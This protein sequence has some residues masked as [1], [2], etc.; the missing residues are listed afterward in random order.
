MQHPRQPIP[1]S[2]GAS[3]VLQ[4][5]QAAT[6]AKDGHASDG[7][8]A[9]RPARRAHHAFL[10]ADEDEML[11]AVATYFESGLEA[12]E[13]AV[14]I[15]TAEHAE[16][17]RQAMGRSYA[18][19]EVM[20]A[21]ATLGLFMLDGMPDEPLFQATVG[22]LLRERRRTSPGIR[23]FGEMVNVLMVRGHADAAI[24]LEAMWNRLAAQVDFELLC[25]Y[26]AACFEHPEGPKRRHQV[27]ATHTSFHSLAQTAQTA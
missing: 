8:V 16:E 21:Q 13:H 20:D 18:R 14:A 17:L 12:G 1:T 19:L 4:A 10:Y 9:Q 6:L 26:E 5:P 7:T 2:A 15:L 24:A 23:A 27:T 25:A 3:A 11:R 22:T